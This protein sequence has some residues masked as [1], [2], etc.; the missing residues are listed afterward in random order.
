MA[1]ITAK[2]P[3]LSVVSDGRYHRQTA[4]LLDG[5]YRRLTRLYQCCQMADIKPATVSTYR[6]SRGRRW[7]VAGTYAA[8]DLSPKV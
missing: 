1:E 2:P 8:A 4:V 6:Y 7:C 3:P 5:R